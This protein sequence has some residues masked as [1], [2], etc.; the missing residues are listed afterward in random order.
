[1]NNGRAP[2]WCYY[3]V[4]QLPGDDAGAFHSS[5]LWHTFGTY[6]RCWRPLTGADGALSA[7][8]VDYWTNF[9]KT[10]DP[11]GGSLPRWEPYRDGSD[12]MIFD[13]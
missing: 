1:M 4:R 5:E 7:R 10:G 12:M 11:N 8:M 13:A 9:M 6:G 2:A 3:F